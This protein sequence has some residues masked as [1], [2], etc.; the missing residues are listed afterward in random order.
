MLKYFAFCYPY[1]SEQ[2]ILESWMKLPDH[3]IQ[4]LILQGAENSPEEKQLL[5]AES[6]TRASSPTLISSRQTV[7][8]IY[9]SLNTKVLLTSCRTETIT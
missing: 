2:R 7:P 5:A 9:R 4:F 1:L 8:S 3:Y 6:T